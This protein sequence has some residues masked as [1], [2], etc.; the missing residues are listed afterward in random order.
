MGHH[1]SSIQ[2]ELLSVYI[3]SKN[4]FNTFVFWLLCSTTST[5]IIT[6]CP[7]K[8]CTGFTWV[9]ANFKQQLVSVRIHRRVSVF[10][11]RGAGLQRC[12]IISASRLQ[13]IE[14]W[15]ASVVICLEGGANDFHMVQLMLLP[16]LT[17]CFIKI[18]NRLT[19][20]VQAH[21]GHSMDVLYER[22][23]HHTSILFF[24][25]LRYLKLV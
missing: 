3:F 19:F 9:D 15:G 22:R 8:W 14:R 13:K 5:F 10:P 23:Y 6:S 20:L 17:S 7:H 4:S 11:V 16:P 25:S 2:P 1:L 18:Q 12:D 21:P 24:F